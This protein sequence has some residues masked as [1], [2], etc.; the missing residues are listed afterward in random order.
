MGMSPK[1]YVP[2]LTW[3]TKSHTHTEHQAKLQFSI[4]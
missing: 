4:F 2:P 3:K 1:D